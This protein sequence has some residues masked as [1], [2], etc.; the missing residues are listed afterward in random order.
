MN[1][2]IFNKAFAKL[3][4]LLKKMFL[5]NLNPT[6]CLKRCY[7]FKTYTGLLQTSKMDCF[8]TT[9]NDF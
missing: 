3:F 7:V 6:I 4:T 2:V 9:G 1:N 5:P 8:E